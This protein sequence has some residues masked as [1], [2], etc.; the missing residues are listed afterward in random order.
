MVVGRRRVSAGS[1]DVKVDV[2]HPADRAFEAALDHGL[3]NGTGEIRRFTACVDGAE[4]FQIGGDQQEFA[5]DEV[6]VDGHRPV[7]AACRAT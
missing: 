7:R 6:G 3:V 5:R 4:G 1:D 2:D